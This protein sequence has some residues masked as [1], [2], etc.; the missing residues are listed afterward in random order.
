MN[1]VQPDPLLARLAAGSE[2]AFAV[3]YDRYGPRMFRV[4]MALLHDRQEAEDAVQ[5]T[6]T[7]LV[8]SRQHLP[9]VND[10]AAYLFATLRRAAG[11]IGRRQGR[12]S[13]RRAELAT[14]AEDRRDHATDTP[15]ADRLRRA[16]G[17]LPAEQ[18]TVIALKIEGELT[19]AQIAEATGVSVNTAASRY[20]Y[21]LE[22]LRGWL[23]RT[24]DHED[25]PAAKMN[26]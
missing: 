5:D 3:L 10:L 18:R 17:A 2:A 20:R 24:S 16:V 13:A 8:R 12:E 14:L 6:F 1:D 22:K 4:A 26:P 23:D 25:P 19:F 11:R 7:S 21:A 9:Q 15:H